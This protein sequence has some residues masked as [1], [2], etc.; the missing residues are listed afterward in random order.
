VTVDHAFLTFRPV[1][2]PHVRWG[3][4]RIDIT[5]RITPRNKV[6]RK[7]LA[8][9]TGNMHFKYVRRMAITSTVDRLA[10]V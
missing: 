7:F 5:S 9:L 2:S 8:L 1:L 4:L 10:A 6:I 3:D